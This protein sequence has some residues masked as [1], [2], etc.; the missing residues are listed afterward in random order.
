[1]NQELQDVQAGFGK[2]RGTKDQIANILWIIDKASALKKA[3]IYFC[4]ID[5]VDHE[6]LWKILQEM[7]IP[8]HLICLLRNLHAGQEQQ[9]GCG[10]RDR[11]Q[12]GKGVFQ[13]CIVSPRL[14]NLCTYCMW[15]VKLDESQ[16]GI[17]IA[18][19][20]INN[21]RYA[22]NTTPMTEREE[23]WTVALNGHES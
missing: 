2:G 3:K 16:A 22:D 4:F 18:R 19:R 10:T 20:N 6:K 1:M 23:E 21:L 7:E 12:I 5:C 9:N 8:D 13:S 17:R 15:N 14:F 11:F